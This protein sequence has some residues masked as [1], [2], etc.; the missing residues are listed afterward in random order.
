MRTTRVRGFERAID[1]NANRA[2]EAVRV[3]EDF[4]RFVLDDRE[5]SA[6]LKKLRHSL[7][8]VLEPLSARLILSRDAARDVGRAAVVES[9]YA[10]AGRLEIVRANAARLAEALRSL[11]EFAKISSPARA[12]KFERLRFRSYELAGKLETSLIRRRKLER[13]GVYAVL[14]T[15]LVEGDVEARLRELLKSGVDA[16]QLR[17]K[18]MPD[19]PYIR[20]AR[21]IAATVR[22]A[23]RLFFV[24]DRVHVCEMVDAD[25]VHLGQSDSPVRQARRVLAP[26][27]IVGLSTHSLAQARGAIAAGCDYISV[28][29]VF[30]TPLKARRRPVGVELVRRVARIAPVPVVAIGGVNGENAGE[31]FAAGA[32]AVALSRPMCR[33][34]NLARLVRGLK[35]AASAAAAEA[36]RENP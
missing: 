2:R 26:S 5:L 4:A 11:E 20:L 25:G 17:E 30:A 24:N 33:G 8:A 36:G 1:A 18:R 28:G 3:L 15:E 10:R 29:P 9:E 16:V 12:K 22:A 21:K 35:R 34:G 27:R 6:E 13:L 32:A 23:G 19:G 31:V 7:S 14:S